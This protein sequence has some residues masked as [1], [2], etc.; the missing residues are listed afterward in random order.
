[1]G[2]GIAKGLFGGSPTKLVAVTLA[3]DKHALA[4][5]DLL[6]PSIRLRMRP[7]PST[8]LLAIAS[9]WMIA[10][11]ALGEMCASPG[12]GQERT[13]VAVPEPSQPPLIRSGR[14]LAKG[15]LAAPENLTLT[16]E[17][18]EDDQFAM[19]FGPGT[20]A[21]KFGTF[22]WKTVKE[23]P[24]AEDGTFFAAL[25]HDAPYV[26][27]VA[28]GRFGFGIAPFE[29][30]GHG[31]PGDA[32]LD[33]PVFVG[34]EL[35]LQLRVDGEATEEERRSLVGRR[36]VVSGSRG[37][38]SSSRGD[39]PAE[40][41]TMGEFTRTGQVDD[42]LRV[43]LPHLP[44]TELRIVARKGGPFGTGE[45]G[46]VLAPFFAPPALRLR[47]E[48]GQA[49][50]RTVLLRR[51]VQY[52]GLVVDA[53]GQ[54]I[55]G[56]TLDT[57]SGAITPI[58]VDRS[59][60]VTDEKG[61]FRVDGLVRMPEKV[62][63]YAKGYMNT[64]LEGALVPA[65]SGERG[66]QITIRKG[67]VLSVRV[68]LPGGRPAQGVRMTLVDPGG[69]HFAKRQK[70]TDDQGVAS[71]E[72][73]SGVPVTISGVAVPVQS[74]RA[75][76]AKS[77]EGLA[78]MRFQFPRKS[79]FAVRAG[80]GKELWVTSADSVSV[81]DAPLELEL[82][83]APRV[84][85][86]L[87]GIDP[88]RGPARVIVAP[89]AEHSTRY[90]LSRGALTTLYLK[91]PATGEFTFQ[92]PPGRYHL[93]AA[94]GTGGGQIPDMAKLRA[95][96]HVDID[97]LEHVGP[98]ELDFG[99]AKPMEGKVRF[100]DGRPAAGLTI[101]MTRLI[102]GYSDASTS[103]E[104]DAEG[105]FRSVPLLAGHYNVYASSADGLVSAWNYDVAF[106]HLEPAP[107]EL[108]AVGMGWV[109]LTFQGDVRSLRRAS[110]TPIPYWSPI[111]DLE[112]GG[113]RVGPM[114]PG[115]YAFALETIHADGSVTMRGKQV[116]VEEG[117][118]TEVELG[119]SEGALAKIEGRV[120]S[121]GQPV[122]GVRVAAHQD[123]FDLAWDTADLEGRFALAVD[124]EGPVELRL[125]TLSRRKL[126]RRSAVATR[127]GCLTA[128]VVLP[129]GAIHVSMGTPLASHEWLRLR[130]LGPTAT[131]EIDRSIGSHSGGS[132]AF[133]Y[134]EDGRYA[135]TRID[136][137]RDVTARAE[138]E[139]KNGA[140][141]RN[142]ILVPTKGL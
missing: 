126:A 85:G 48:A 84:R 27:F 67:D 83:H 136:W 53:S 64:V 107:V 102:G 57:E 108:E 127:G 13:P 36:V 18:S 3:R 90:G 79:D 19:D 47:A 140:V 124:A 5:L 69:G 68:T 55:A 98:V 104:T 50:Q 93:A 65:P 8:C 66:A 14:I 2:R 111:A 34:G 91:D 133:I 25:P 142:V 134:L 78:P 22:E 123:K 49:T 7:L 129:T 30:N 52:A 73:L 58:S 76:P 39:W 38:M 72:H 141:V 23:V 33:L 122:P 118:T 6:L 15:L 117:A 74:D 82:R 109:Q 61:R 97:A 29:V 45:G 62:T 37:F 31:D 21:P 60:S 44:I 121:G 1:M 116:Q 137:K 17:R 89:V 105:S 130:R 46:G 11:A 80:G 12:W 75:M 51:G 20:D 114:R 43:V 132:N 88:E 16:L 139:I 59:R 10:A 26:R 24:I 9:Y 138:V 119:S 101:R 113:D 96:P 87:K 71:F 92:L 95:T 99:L 81:F 106:D 4:A 100:A 125:G 94:Q 32:A 115:R 54:P 41:G 128:D 110:Q 35:A 86:V 40:G 103:A 56:A 63:V 120:T 42:Q 131:G 28:R 112:A 135:V 77:A 70:T